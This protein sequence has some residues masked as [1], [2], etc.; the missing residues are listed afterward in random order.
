M[1]TDHA[2]HPLLADIAAIAHPRPEPPAGIAGDPAAAETYTAALAE[3]SAR[4][5][6]LMD[7]LAAAWHARDADPLLS[8]L[9]GARARKERAE[10]EIRALVAYGREVVRPRSYTLT[11]LAEASGMS[12]SGVRT[13]YGD[14]DVRAAR[15]GR[16]GK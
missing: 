7:E 16:E 13:V 14:A 5:T 4:R 3:I 1:T 6:S 2:F 12:F 11:S 9:A 15:A 10:A 8:A